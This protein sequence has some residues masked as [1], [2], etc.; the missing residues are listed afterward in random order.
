MGSRFVSS[1]QWQNASEAMRPYKT[2]LTRLHGI[3]GTSVAYACKRD[4]RAVDTDVKHL[5]GGGCARP[6][7]LHAGLERGEEKRT[8]MSREKRHRRKQSQSVDLK[9]A[10]H[11]DT[12]VSRNNRDC[13]SPVISNAVAQPASS[14]M[15][16]LLVG[17]IQTKL[18]TCTTSAA[19]GHRSSV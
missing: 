19:D 17:L 13:H 15:P 1:A 9:D 11:E 4:L 3:T 6:Q 14:K 12:A 8:R 7:Q 10:M 16:I 2:V 18:G 5:G